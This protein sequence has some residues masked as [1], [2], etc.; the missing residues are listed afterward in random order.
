VTLFR[1]K[2]TF[3]LDL[4]KEDAYERCLRAA[5]SDIG[6]ATIPNEDH[7][8]IGLT[9]MTPWRIGG[10]FRTYL[11]PVDDGHTEVTVRGVGLVKKDVDRVAHQIQ[12]G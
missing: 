6:A 5:S 8:R 3:V 11:R 12:S 4:P 2:E 9:I 1:P 7:S 10:M